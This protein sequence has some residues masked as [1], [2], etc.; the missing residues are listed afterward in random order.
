M[1]SKTQYKLF[2]FSFYLESYKP[3]NVIFFLHRVSGCYQRHSIIW[4][5]TFVLAPHKY[6]LAPHFITPVK[7]SDTVTES[8][9]FDLHCLFTMKRLHC[10]M[11]LWYRAWVSP[12]HYCLQLL[13]KQLRHTFF[14]KTWTR[15]NIHKWDGNLITILYPVNLYVINW[16]LWWM[17]V[18]SYLHTAGFG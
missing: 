9:V 8:L 11:H 4:Y 3:I 17:F 18:K 1:Y 13:W 10:T 5:W 14:T 15:N 7:N 6:V 2:F 12:N 16:V